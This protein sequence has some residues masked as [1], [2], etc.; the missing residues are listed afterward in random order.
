MSVRS[1]LLHALLGALLIAGPTG[2]RAAD[3]ALLAAAGKAVQVCADHMPDS[4]AT[5]DALV[6]EGYRY[7]GS[8]GVYH[9]YSLNG[10]RVVVG[11]TVTHS[12]DQACTILVSK[13]TPAE[14]VQLIQPWVRAANATPV[15]LERADMTA[16]WR[17][18]FRGR[19]ANVGIIRNADAEI[20]RGAA[21]ILRIH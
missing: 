1:R 14:A 12:S 17:G 10:R 9:Y 16:G 5:K 2:V 8:D 20:V 18:V 15:P 13:M 3:P 19:P 11:T 21:I 7:E 4:R 6:A